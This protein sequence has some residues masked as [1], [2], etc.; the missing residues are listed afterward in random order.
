MF[1]MFS[2]WL[3]TQM[4]QQNCTIVFG[5]DHCIANSQKGF[6]N[7]SRCNFGRFNHVC[8]EW[9][10]LAVILSSQLFINQRDP[11]GLLHYDHFFC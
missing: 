7:G 8:F 3:S 9:P 5:G 4:M 11:D 1:Y 10:D 6:D 2:V